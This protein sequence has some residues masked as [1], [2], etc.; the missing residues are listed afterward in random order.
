[1]CGFMTQSIIKCLGVFALV[2]G[3]SAPALAAPPTSPPPP[4]G[5]IEDIQGTLGIILDRLDDLEGKVDNLQTDVDNLPTGVDLRGVTQNW[6]KKLDATNGGTTAGREGCDSDRFTCLFGDTA[7][8]DNETGIVWD[9]DPDT[10]T[11]TWASSIS[12]CANREVGGRKGWSL[13]MRE[14]LA[15]LVDRTGTGVDGNGDPLKLP[16]GHPFLNVQSANYWSASTNATVPVLAWV[17]N[18]FFGAVTTFNKDPG[19]DRAWCV[20]GG[21]VYDGQDVLQAP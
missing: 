19:T 4:A 10:G 21:Q 5:P 1:M 17:V 6:D 8:R 15:T 12:H 9:R 13:P 20:R 3:L 2:L 11:R 14:Q 16:D 18:F 7:V